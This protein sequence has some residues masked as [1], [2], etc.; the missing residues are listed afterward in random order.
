MVADTLKEKV[1][2]GN[3]AIHDYSPS[4]REVQIKIDF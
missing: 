3:I 4:S 1:S 2:L